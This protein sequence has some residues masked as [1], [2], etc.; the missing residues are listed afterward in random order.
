[1]NVLNIFQAPLR[2]WHFLVP[3]I[4]CYSVPLGFHCE[5]L[6]ESGS[7]FAALAAILIAVPL[8]RRG[9]RIP[10]ALLEQGSGVLC[11]FLIECATLMLLWAGVELN[12]GFAYI[13]FL[14]ACMA[15][16]CWLGSKRLFLALTRVWFLA[17]LFMPLTS[18]CLEVVSL[19]VFRAVLNPA[20]HMLDFCLVPND[21]V[22]GSLNLT[23]MR[24]IDS[25]NGYV[26]GVALNA[27]ATSFVLA[28]LRDRSWFFA[29]SASLASL[30]AM[31][32]LMFGAV[33]LQGVL[34]FHFN[35][36]AAPWFVTLFVGGIILALNLALL[37]MGLRKTSWIWET[38]G[39]AHRKVESIFEGCDFSIGLFLVLLFLV[40]AGFG[41]SCLF[42]IGSPVLAYFGG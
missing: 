10:P 36:A 22:D 8:V 29:F 9:C 32:F 40:V 33:I 5:W 41:T 27:V 13:S 34:F 30:L 16:V 31:P 38:N 3:A 4:L 42:L 21:V 37:L 39:P 14:L 1:M 28:F 11:F 20:S 25:R 7:L 12:T 26:G 35:T 18:S 24:S 23:G 2:A 15:A 17:I 6:W 19:D